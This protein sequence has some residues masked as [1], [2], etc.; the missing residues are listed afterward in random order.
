MPIRLI[1][2]DLDDTLLKED[3][4]ISDANREALRA[5]HAAGARIV[6]AS[7]R[8]IYSMEAYARILGLAGPDDY[9]ICS[10]GA[11][12]VETATGR[13]LYERRMEPELC[14]DV[15]R[16]LAERGFPWQVYEGGRIL[17]SARNPWTDED[18][19]LTGQPNSLVEDEEALFARGQ[20]KY[21]VPGDPAR[22]PA[23]RDEMALLF[24]GRAEVLV[25]KPY[26][27]EVLA[28]GVDKGEALSRLA[29]LLGLGLESTM[30]C[31]D[32]MNDLGMLRAAGLSC[33]PAN[34]IPAAKEAARFVSP[35]T[36]DEDFVADAV[37]RFVLAP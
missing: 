5:A 3:L 9:L 13:R 31:G 24:E 27:M 32:A 11:E 29:A 36:N 37:R 26:F 8:N 1:A 14:R 34:A 23:L 16:A 18:T 17:A 25:S 28:A 22:I 35:L 19:R 21:V 30:A 6:L 12:I 10:N 33:A 2:L 15:A 20:V 4:S 7:G